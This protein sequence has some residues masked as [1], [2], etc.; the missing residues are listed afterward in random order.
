MNTHSHTH[1]HKEVK[2][3]S[4]DEKDK[5]L[6]YIAIIKTVHRVADS[7]FIS[8]HENRTRGISGCLVAQK[9]TRMRRDIQ[10]EMQFERERERESFPKI[11]K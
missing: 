9:H 10:N 1:T 6:K 11:T 2:Q 4:F 5:R 3:A 7:L 8:I